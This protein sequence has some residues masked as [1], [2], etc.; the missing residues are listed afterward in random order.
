MSAMVE[1]RILIQ[2]TVAVAVEV[3]ALRGRL[4]LRA[5]LRLWDCVGVGTFTIRRAL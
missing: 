5:T 3:E 2:E 4:R 1:P